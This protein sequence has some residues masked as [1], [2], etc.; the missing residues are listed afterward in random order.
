MFSYCSPHLKT[1]DTD[2]SWWSSR[3][4]NSKEKRRMPLSLEDL[5]VLTNSLERL[6]FQGL[7]PTKRGLKNS[8]KRTKRTNLQKGSTLNPMTLQEIILS[9]EM[10]L[11]KSIQDWARC[12]QIAMWSQLTR[13]KEGA[14]A[15]FNQSLN[16]EVLEA[17]KLIIRQ[18]VKVRAHQTES[19]GSSL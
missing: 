13:L 11:Q 12:S 3:P 7:R 1:M 10:S 18:L 6:M 2:S 14:G 8:S 5:K 4:L 16:L 9:I 17:L 19:S 15:Q